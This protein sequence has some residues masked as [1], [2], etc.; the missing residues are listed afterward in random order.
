MQ[1]YYGEYDDIYDHTPYE[2]CILEE[3][4]NCWCEK[5]GG[6]ICWYE[7]CEDA[8]IISN[9][10]NKT[11]DNVKYNKHYIKRKR[12]NRYYRDLKH[13]N[14]VKFLAQT[15][16]YYPTPA[17]PVDENGRYN[18]NDPVGTVYYRRIYKGSHKKNRYKFYKKHANRAVRRYKGKIGNGCAYKKCFEY[19]WKVD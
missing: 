9:K 12:S 13:K 18:F 5:I 14:H 16:Q 10:S 15:I 3:E 4:R 19:A 11:S 7:Q 17:M 6:R 1:W 8:N 2:A